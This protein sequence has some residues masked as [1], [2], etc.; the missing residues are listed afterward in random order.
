MKF[1][2]NIEGREVF[3]GDVDVLVT[4]GFAGNVFLKTSEGVSAFI[5]DALKQ[6]FASISSPAVD[7]VFQ[8]LNQHLNYAEYPGA[9]LCGVDGI[10]IKCHGNSSAQAMRNGIKGALQL[11]QNQFLDKMKSLLQ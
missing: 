5:L 11:T 4:D 8:K 2:G 9:V 10:A 6:A 3:R 1:L 7:Q